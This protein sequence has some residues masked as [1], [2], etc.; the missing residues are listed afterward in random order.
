MKATILT[1]NLSPERLAKL[2]FLCMKLGVTVQP[3][4]AEDFGQPVGALCGLAARMESAPAQGF[5]AEMLVFCQMDNALVSRFLTTCRQ[6][7]W[8]APGLKAI[9]TPTNAG[10]TAVQ[11]QAELARER[12][13]VLR[14]ESPNHGD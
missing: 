2:R 9:L 5:D 13:A 14:G 8:A 3:V 6:M 10:W 1:F 7:R 12:Q 4:P 11:L